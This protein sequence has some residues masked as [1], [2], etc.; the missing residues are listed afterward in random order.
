MM[1]LT[2]RSAFESTSA[3]HWVLTAS[4]V[5]D[6]HSRYRRLVEINVVQPLGDEQA[7]G[8]GDALRVGPDDDEKL[9]PLDLL[10]VFECPVLRNFPAD[11]RARQAAQRGSRQ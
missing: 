5:D 8:A 1:S 11:E 6:Q 4:F 7:P 9:A 2:H 3:F 10:L